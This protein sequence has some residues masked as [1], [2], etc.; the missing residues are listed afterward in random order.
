MEGEWDP[1]WY[2]TDSPGRLACESNSAME[3]CIRTGLPSTCVAVD[4]GL[5]TI[6]VCLPIPVSL[7]PD[8]I[9]EVGSTVL[10]GL[11]R[12][13]VRFGTAPFILTSVGPLIT[14]FWLR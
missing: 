14:T 3:P 13:P 4:V 8:T 10:T 5:R 1:T 2:G 12:I 9:P 6:S 7:C 11:V